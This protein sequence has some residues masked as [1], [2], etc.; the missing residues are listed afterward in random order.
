MDFHLVTYL[1]LEPFSRKKM[2]GSL[3]ETYYDALAEEFREMGVNPY[4]EQLSKQEFEQS[5][6]DF[7]L[8]GATYNCIAATVLRLP[9]N[10]LKNLKDERPEDFHRFCNVDRSADVLRLMKNHP[11]FADYMYDCVGDLLALT[12]HK[13][14]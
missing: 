5:L 4:Q 14:H 13:L 6:N 10:Y 8:F 12:Y 2:I 9:D 7:S 11:E 1:N 3:I